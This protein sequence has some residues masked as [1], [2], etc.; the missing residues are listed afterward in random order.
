MSSGYK[1]NH[2]KDNAANYSISTNMSTKISALQIAE[3]NAMQGLDMLNSASST[4]EEMQEMTTRLRALATQARNATYSADSL[5][6]INAEA[7]A[8]ITEI[9]RLNDTAEYNG[10]KLLNNYTIKIPDGVGTDGNVGVQT[11]ATFALRETTVGP[12]KPTYGKFIENPVEYTADQVANMDKMSELAGTETITEG[13]YSIST[14]EDLAKLA[15]MT[16]K[17]LITGGEFVLANDIDLKKYLETHTWNAIGSDS[18]KFSVIF[19]GNGHSIINLTASGKNGLISRASDGAVIKNVGIE[20]VNL[21]NGSVMGPLLGSS[22]GEGVVAVEVYNCFSTGIIVAGGTTGGLIGTCTKKTIITSCY[23]DIDFTCTS[24]ASTT[25]SLLGGLVSTASNNSEIINCFS[26]GTMT[27]AGCNIG[28]LTASYSNTTISNC[29]SEVDLDIEGNEVGGLVGSGSGEIT[30]CYATGNVSGLKSVGGLIGGTGTTAITSNCYATGDVSG[31]KYVGGLIGY[32]A[33]KINNCYATGNV[34]GINYVGGLSGTCNTVENCYATGNVLGQDKV[35]GLVGHAAKISNSS[36]EGNVSGETSVGG[37][38]G[39]STYQPITNCYSKGNVSGSNMVG[40]LIGNIDLPRYTAK[41]TNCISYSN[42][43]GTNA[44]GALIGSFT[45][46]EDEA[47]YGILRLTDVSAASQNMSIIG[48]A[49]NTGGVLLTNYDLSSQEK[50]V[51]TFI[52][53]STIISLQI[54]INSDVNSQITFDTVAYGLIDSLNG[55]QMESD[56]SI[57][58]IDNV[59]SALGAKQVEYGAAI[60]RVEFALDEISTQYENLV[61]SRST[62]RD[63]DMAELSSTYVQQQI[64]QQATATLMSTANQ[65]P[66]IALQLI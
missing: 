24:S 23:S 12:P 47:T 41:I 28:G 50:S 40:G 42:V 63:A 57:A 15:T 66:A 54:G 34:V 7:G 35:G 4:L 61:S 32:D 59:I 27:G 22:A 11:A 62:I 14:P 2:A 49:Y 52:I 46:T 1:V 29:Y 5:S 51:T 20:N 48:G 43:S 55:L 56:N 58:I 45:C 53:P 8:I 6:A 37:L 60:N 44:T 3:D 21:T 16:D 30:N 18:H 65:S 31:E 33:G 9:Q 10:I 13:Q 39:E 17:G 25:H 64:L 19:N 36:A 26:K 38:V